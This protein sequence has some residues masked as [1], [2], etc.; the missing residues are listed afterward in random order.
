MHHG[1]KRDERGLTL[2]ELIIVMAVIAIIGAILAP[3]FL[4]ATDRARLKSDIQSAKV[5]QTAIETYNAEQSAAIGQ[6]DDVKESILAA[7]IEKGY[8]SPS[9]GLEPQTA[10]A[11]WSY[12][13]DGIVKLNIDGCDAKIKNDIFKALSNEEKAL[14]K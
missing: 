10:G 8:L 14:I 2:M 7:I 12:G 11:I 13:E 6:A 9:S 5:I 4:S 3:N 1:F